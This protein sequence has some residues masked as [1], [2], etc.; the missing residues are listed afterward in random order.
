ALAGSWPP[1][2]TPKNMDD[3]SQADPLLAQIAGPVASFIAHGAY[4]RGGVAAAVAACHPEAA[5]V[6]PPCATVV[7]SSTAESAP[8]QRNSHLQHIARHGRMPWQTTS[9]YSRRARVEVTMN[10]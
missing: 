9:G 8:T 7:P 5:V 3:A 1:R 4:D 10:R 2:W 6:V